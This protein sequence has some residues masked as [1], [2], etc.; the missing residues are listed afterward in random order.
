MTRGKSDPKTGR[1]DVRGAPRA[2]PRLPSSAAEARS[3]ARR[4]GTLASVVP[5]GPGE[6]LRTPAQAATRRRHITAETG[7]TLPVAACSSAPR[8]PP[9]PLT[10]RRLTTG[11]A[12]RAPDAAP[13]PPILIDI[14]PAVSRRLHPWPL[15]CAN[16]TAGSPRRRRSRQSSWKPTASSSRRAMFGE[17]HRA[18]IGDDAGRHARPATTVPARPGA[19]AGP[20]RRAVSLSAP[21]PH[22]RRPHVTP[23]P[24]TSRSIRPRR[25]R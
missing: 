22:Q 4:V 6:A 11:G 8:P 7:N 20:R 12:E 3:L 17:P 14:D 15:R 5:A 18:Q 23:K 21:R 2:R 13:A 24:S 10:R 9:M 16:S 25:T 1:P 19:A